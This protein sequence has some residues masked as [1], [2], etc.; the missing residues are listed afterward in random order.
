MTYKFE[1]PAH[2]NIAKKIDPII[3]SIYKYVHQLISGCFDQDTMTRNVYVGVSLQAFRNSII[4]H[5]ELIFLLATLYWVWTG[6]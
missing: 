5:L 4:D 2:P 1:M 6:Q 3:L